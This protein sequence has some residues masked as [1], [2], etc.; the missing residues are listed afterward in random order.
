MNTLATQNNSQ[1]RSKSKRKKKRLTLRRVLVAMG[2]TAALAIVCATIGYMVIMYNGQQYLEKYADRMEMAE[3]SILYDANGREVTVLYRE[4]RELVQY[5]EIPPMLTYAFIATEDKRF[6]EHAGIDFWAIG[7]AAVKDILA[8]A[9][10]EGGSTITQQLAKNMFLTHEKTFFRKATEAAIAIALE[11]NYSKEKILEMYL[12]RIYFGSGAYGIKAAAKTYFG[13]SDL[14]DLELWQMATLA[15]IPKSPRNYSPLLNPEKSKERRKVVLRLM[16]EQGYITEEAMRQAAEVDYEPPSGSNMQFKTYQDYVLQE[17]EDVFGIEE[18]KILRGGYHIYTYLDT[19]AQAAMES[20]F[21]NPE[22]FQEDGPEQPMQGS[23]VIIDHKTGGIV[24][25][26]GGRDY[27]NKGLNRALVKR[28]PGSSFKPLVVYAPAIETGKWNPYSMLKDELLDYN[29]YKPRNYDNVYRGQVDM[30]EAVRKSYNAPAVWLL[31]EIGITTG[32]N[33]AKNLGIEF[34]PEDRNLAIA[35]GGMTKGVTPLQMAQAYAAFANNGVWIKAHA[36]REIVDDNGVSIKAKPETKTV[37]SPKTAYYMTELLQ[38]V[39]R[40]GT[41]QAAKMNRPVAGKTGTTQLDIKGL[42]KYNRDIWFAGYTPEWTAAVWMGFDRTDKNHY[43]GTKTSYAAAMFKQVMSEA[44][45]DRPVTDFVR[46]EGVSDPKEPPKAVT[47]LKAE[48]QPD[49]HKVVLTWTEPGED[50]DLTYQLYRKASSDEEFVLLAEVLKGT[51]EFNDYTVMPGNRYEYYMLTVH[52]ETK[53][54]SA[55]SNPAV[56]E[57]PDTG[58]GGTGEDGDLP[59]P[60]LSPLLP[61]E[62]AGE[63]DEWPTPLPDDLPTPNPSPIDGSVLPDPLDTDDGGNDGQLDTTSGEEA[64]GTLE[65][66]FL[67]PSP[68]PSEPLLPGVLPGR[69]R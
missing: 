33:F 61:G 64:G 53:Q 24:A 3:A 59:L 28:Q 49:K 66:R 8:G 48:Y 35:L 34:E 56:V 54:A 52:A 29:G 30:F 17:I 7:R 50:F 6:N 43:I 23:M 46:P 26:I 9:M 62:D 51:T 44:L 4:N 45:K 21:G 11:E 38:E 18:E 19:K 58:E 27:V 10:V 40:S 42:E 20:A 68:V 57:L 31:N 14:N 36:V 65:D 32:M 69:G 47:D 22:L 63:D 13:I 5:S 1:T 37:M 39:V 60:D 2:V 55:Q 12:N 16:Y 67:H 41:G 15:G 25:M